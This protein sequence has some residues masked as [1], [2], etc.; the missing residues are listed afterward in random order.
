MIRG[1]ENSGRLH[2]NPNPNR[3]IGLKSEQMNQRKGKRMARSPR[4][5]A[6]RRAGEKERKGTDFKSENQTLTLKKKGSLPGLLPTAGSIATAR[7]GDRGVAPERRAGQGRD[8]RCSPPSGHGNR[9]PPCGPSTAACSASGEHARRREGA[10]R[11][12]LSSPSATEDGCCC[13]SLRAA[14]RGER[15]GEEVK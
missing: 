10:G 4:R 12:R 15:E 9:A 3:Q 7:I 5:R 6:R 11:C 2:P 13:G 1:K 8:P 14:L